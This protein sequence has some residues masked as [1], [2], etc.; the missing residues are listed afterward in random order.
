M[1][2][3]SSS[4][5]IAQPIVSSVK[6]DQ[7]DDV[8]HQYDHVATTIPQTRYM[9]ADTME[10]IPQPQKLPMYEDN[11]PAARELRHK[12]TIAKLEHMRNAMHGYDSTQCGNISKADLTTCRKVVNATNNSPPTARTIIQ[13]VSRS[14]QV[15]GHSIPSQSPSTTPE[16]V[17]SQPSNT[18]DLRDIR[19]APATTPMADPNEPQDNNDAPSPTNDENRG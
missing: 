15:P 17:R 12:C 1:N 6:A 9:D 13:M 4:Q 3:S 5:D 10:I 19:T 11:S 16:S 8:D 18:F 14:T 2:T 7:D